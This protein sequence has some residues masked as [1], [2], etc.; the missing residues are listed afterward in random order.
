MG[1]VAD[2]LQYGAADIFDV[3]GD[4]NYL[5]PFLK[6]LVLSI[7]LDAGEIRMDKAKWAEVACEN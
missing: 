4:S 1:K 6:A 3:R 7:D 5:V 2:V